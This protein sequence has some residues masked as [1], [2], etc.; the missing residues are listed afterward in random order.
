[1]VKSCRALSF[2]SACG[3][4]L[5]LITGAGAQ[6]FNLIDRTGQCVTSPLLGLSQNIDPPGTSQIVRSADRFRVPDGPD[7]RL[8][9]VQAQGTFS[10]SQVNPLGADVRIFA[11]DGASPGPGTQV[12]TYSFP[13]AEIGPLA[14]SGQ[15]DITLPGGAQAC[16]LSAGDYW[17]SVAFLGTIGVNPAQGR[18]WYWNQ[19]TENQQGNWQMRAADDIDAS[20]INCP[21]WVTR[22][23]CSAVTQ[24]RGLC[25]AISG[26]TPITLAEPLADQFTSAGTSFL[27]DVSS[28]FTDPDGD[29][30][31]YQAIGLPASLT[32][33]EAT[34]RISGTIEA[35]DVAGSPYTVEITA[36]DDDDVSAEDTFRLVV[37]DDEVAD[38]RFQRLWPVLQQPWYFG[39]SAPDLSFNGST[40]FVANP[41][42]SRIQRFSPAGKHISNLFIPG[43][44][45]PATRGKPRVLAA[46]TRAVFTAGDLDPQIYKL[47]LNGEVL[48]RFGADELAGQVPQFLE[49]T[50]RGCRRLGGCVYVGLADEVLKFSEDGQFLSRFGLCADPPCENGTVQQLG[51]LTVGPD[52]LVYLTD[53]AEDQL[54]ILRTSP[55]A[56]L[57]DPPEFLAEIGEPGSGPG[58]FASPGDVSLDGA[59]RVYV[60]DANRVQ[61]FS[62]QGVPLDEYVAPSEAQV[63]RRLE[64]GPERL[65]FGSN[66]LAQVTRFRR[67]GDV[68][69][70]ASTLNFS[71]PFSSAD[72]R[73]GFFQQP[74]DL[75]TGPNSNV[76]V[77]DA[78]NH[79]VQKFDPAGQLLNAFGKEGDEDGEFGR[80]IAIG[81][82][83][84]AGEL[85]AHVLDENITGYRIQ[86]F[87]SGGDFVDSIALPGND[88]YVD[89]EIGS[90][91][92]A[93]L[94]TAA[95]LAVKVSTQGE[96]LATWEPMASGAQ[97]L[98]VAQAP[99]GLFYFTVQG[100]SQEGF[101]IYD[102]FG[103]F[104][105]FLP[106]TFNAPASLS[107]AG[108]GK[109]VLGEI[110]DI[111]PDVPRIKIYRQ[112]GVLLQSVGQYG[113]FPGSFAAPAGLDF[114]PNGLL[115][116]SDSVNNYVQVLDPVPPAEIT[117]AVVVAG[118][119]PYP[120][121]NLWETT[122]ALT[123]G[124]YLALAYQ[125]LRAED[126]TYL[127]SN[128]DEDLDGNGISDVDFPASAPSLVTAISMAADG[129]DR[130][131]V[132]LADH[133]SEDVFRVSPQS[134]LDAA[135][136]DAALDSAQSGPTAVDQLVLIY[137]AC[138][139]GSFV[140]DLASPGLNR[141]VLAS[142]GAD[143][144]AKFV[145][146]GILSFS[147]QFWT[148]IFTGADLAAAY[149]SASQIMTTS[150]SDQTPLADADGDANPNES[151]DDLTA[152]SGVFI[153]AG[154]NFDP[155]APV[156]ASVSDPQV[157]A[158]GNEAQISAFGVT[159]PDG[160]ARVYAEIV[161]P[162]FVDGDIDQPVQAFPGFELEPDAPGSSD[163]TL[164][165][166]RFSS[167][168][169]YTINVYAQDRFGNLSAPA[170]TT[171]TAG[172]PELRKALLIVGGET[173]DPRWSAYSAN[174]AFAYAA[175]T[176]QGYSDAGLETVRYLSN[177]GTD[178]VDDVASSAT[179]AGAFAWAGEQA[180]D[181]VVYLVGGV[182][183]GA[184]R[185][186]SGERLTA[187]ELSGYLDML[188]ASI[189]GKLVVLYDGNRSGAFLPRLTSP[190]PGRRI[191]LTSTAASESASFLLE[192]A[193]S[194]SQ[195]FWNQVLNGATVLEAF[196]TARDAVGFSAG[197]QTPQL[198]DNANGEGND[199]EDGFVASTYDIG[200]G[201]VQDINGPSAGALTPDIQ[202]TGGVTQATITVNN[203][204]S[205]SGVDEVF[206]IVGSP[207]PQQTSD[208][209]VLAPVTVDGNG[210]GQYDGTYANF[211]PLPGGGYAAGFYLVTVYVRDQ[212]GNIALHDTVRVEQSAGPDGWEDDDI[213][214]EASVI[215]VDD[216][217]AQRH[218]LHED[219]DS[220]F[221]SF[222]AVNRSGSAQT[223]ELSVSEIDDYSGGTYNV[224]LELYGPT[225]PPGSPLATATG[226]ISGSVSLTW[227]SSG[228]SYD[229]GEGEYYL[230]VLAASGTQR[231]RYAVRVFR[232]AVPLTGAVRGSVVDA[233]TGEPVPGA[234]IAT[235]GTVAA[236]SNLI[237]EY[238]LVE[239][240]GTYSLTV[241]PPAGYLPLTE[242]NVPVSESLTT[243]RL[244]QVQP[245]GAAP[246]VQTGEATGITQTTA[247]LNGLVAPNGE[248]TAVVFE[249]LPAG[250][251]IT[252]PP[253]VAGDAPQSDA[254][255]Q[256]TGLTC[257]TDYTFRI[258]ASNA[259]GSSNGASE[260]LRTADC[261]APP[262][263][264]TVTASNL[265]DETARLEASV[266]PVGSETI[267][268]FR[269]R[270]AGGVFNPYQDSPDV[271]TGS[272]TQV[273]G[274]NIDTLTCATVYDYQARAS[275]A[276]G[277]AE[278]TVQNFSTAVCPQTPPT[279]VTLAA[280]NITETGADLRAS[281]DANGDTASVEYRINAVGDAP[282]AWQT[283]GTVATSEQVTVTVSSLDCGRDYQYRFR[284][285]N[286]GGTTEGSDQGLTTLDCADDFP[287]VQTD[288]ATLVGQTSATVNALVDPN[289]S[290]TQV[291]FDYGLSG[292]LDETLA[293]E[294]PLEG[295]DPVSQSARLEGLAC[296][297]QYSYRVRGS[298]TAGTAFGATRTFTTNPCDR[299]L[300][301]D[302]DS[303]SPDLTP[304]YGGLLD[305]LGFAYT[306]WNTGGEDAE[307]QAGDLAPYSTV[308]W[309]TGD[310]AAA[311]TGPGPAG[312]A[313]LAD[314]LDAGGCLALS[315]QNYFAV[316]GPTPTTLMS[317]YLGV[318][319]G[320]ANAGLQNVAGV[321]SAFAGLPTSG[322][323]L[324]D[325]AGASLS[326]AADELTVT[327]GGEVAFE[328]DGQATAG[329]QVIADS[330]R[331]LFL[332]FPLAA[333]PGA[334]EGGAA[335]SAVLDFCRGQDVLFSN[336]FE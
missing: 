299:I 113:Y 86:R 73:V 285:S 7:W 120:G 143:E 310:N 317:D 174:G 51:G 220:D 37:A 211:G 112:D 291:F 128:L 106:A 78:G 48:D 139:A 265:S 98:Q 157:L 262:V 327:G 135:A 152:L 121:N 277:T 79:R 247:T 177:G 195:F 276:G 234:L 170:T 194:F 127:S 336:G 109:I 53:Q 238:Q 180:Q 133:G 187:L 137:D 11:N 197:D 12:C 290:S 21:D 31:F 207:P 239:N 189:S 226:G 27:M 35:G 150:F 236:A 93:F 316:R 235:S 114:A 61:A 90:G 99:N 293:L 132:Y 323:Y 198:D 280:Q 15:F 1:M 117:R 103:N 282:G 130:L 330:Y 335:L 249:I 101:A 24:E 263:L 13:L 319:G 17:F 302:D 298:N 284:A 36:T 188:E 14:N 91:G 311:G 210:N 300:L 8:D 10:G 64:F 47:G 158:D 19:S 3:L 163:Y 306:V 147:N 204:T 20:G 89:M 203:V 155:G 124:A 320:V 242:N 326:S 168:G 206:A 125:G 55:A 313:A 104:V 129:A 164:I 2:I 119:G 107:V 25:F 149:A 122:Q 228:N 156:I 148:Q 108:D 56:A 111:A 281:V 126:I 45:G 261:V 60:A 58:Q 301:V 82:G 16:Q 138:R 40:L 318:A 32:L 213:P 264:T 231:G 185:L 69:A 85:R 88:D 181:V 208:T 34:G 267:T 218:T 123:N 246:S 153:G 212:R 87:T 248:L 173:S 41:T 201:I 255:A 328:G 118:G 308:L 257:E 162:N 9:S 161:P 266:D 274:L 309:F 92:A 288:P 167:E 81:T 18:F 256:V 278:S 272:G 275:N 39:T 102:R 222:N 269:W 230:R 146:G 283:A 209:F 221:V 29:D 74:I 289:G 304:V 251:A 83:S 214:V 254:A 250:P 183:S 54:I 240:P 324:L 84:I 166:D 184:L 142:T 253:D 116:I 279:V 95:G 100:Q 176:A 270:P 303:N 322:T 33:N 67:V 193:L 215:F 160:V 287:E 42:F 115:Y 252:Q 76:Y 217:D 169:T 190:N 273:A 172:N 295:S 271:L 44:G 244:L 30:A 312:E 136:L 110:P 245:S 94:V 178:G 200:A 223:Y 96:V 49:A 159:D 232:P 333:I 224:T 202:L 70:G 97:F 5:G 314:Y 43:P 186:A 71:T 52:G 286:S 23:Q 165:F 268:A 57:I 259:T 28:A 307:P 175:L 46:S 294:S 63:L 205:A 105:A 331:S 182:R 199:A 22:E 334:A 68:D 196:E 296:G 305:T 192:G 179:V 260:A 59:G 233:L 229:E 26:N 141:I 241:T 329:I 6:P 321:S 151:A 134:V 171:V 4:T 145:S 80:M 315:A 216:A 66:D 297:Q 225:T 191:L 144:S 38:F 140:D 237:G 325:F 258:T 62:P 219:D 50:E 292:L 227:P 332:G 131:V 77:A 154:T 75:A 243:W 65:A 72:D